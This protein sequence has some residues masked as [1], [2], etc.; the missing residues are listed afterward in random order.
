MPWESR[1][2]RSLNNEFDK[3]QIPRLDFASGLWQQINDKIKGY[4]KRF[5][6]TGVTFS[7]RFPPA[8]L[9]D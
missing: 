9:A 6:H 5:T 4:R 2:V 7:D 3:K 1:N 8:S